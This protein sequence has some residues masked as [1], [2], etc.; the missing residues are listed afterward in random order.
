[1]KKIISSIIILSLI[2]CTVFVVSSLG[3]YNKAEAQPPQI[4]NRSN[5]DQT[6]PFGPTLI[7]PGDE[8]TV[9]LSK[10]INGAVTVSF[11]C[12]ETNSGNEI[13][14]FE[15][16]A[17]VSADAGFTQTF[18]NPFASAT[19]IWCTLSSEPNTLNPSNPLYVNVEIRSSTCGVRKMYVA[20]PYGNHRVVVVDANAGW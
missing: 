2:G 20:D 6:I 1:M 16:V 7:E 15:V 3:N 14:D 17:E 18:D 9:Q 13:Q 8:V 11:Q 10:P 12:Y 5:V 19:S 4:A